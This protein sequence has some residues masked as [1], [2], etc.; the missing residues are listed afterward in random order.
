MRILLN[1]ANLSTGGGLSTGGALIQNWLQRADVLRVLASPELAGFLTDLGIPESSWIQVRQRPG[2]SLAARWA[3]RTL[4]DETV[5]TFQPDIVFTV[6]GPPLWR[7]RAPHVCGFANGLYLPKEPIRTD[8]SAHSRLQTL[9]HQIRRALLFRSLRT[10]TDAIWVETET[11]RQQL[12]R[13]LP[14]KPIFV[15]PNELPDAFKQT[16][17]ELKPAVQQPLR[18]LMPAA[19]Y[20][21]KNFAL[22]RSLLALPDAS[23]MQF[24]VTLHPQ[25]FNR[26]FPDYPKPHNLGFLPADQLPKAY[27]NADVIFA[28]SLAEI[29]SATW[30][31][32]MAAKRPLVC[33]DIPEA[34]DL[35]DNAALYFSGS[36]A[37]EALAVLNSLRSDPVLLAIQVRNGIARLQDLTPVVS[38]PEALYRLLS[39]TLAL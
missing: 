5:R 11:V 29:Y 6:F 18:I 28:P 39:Q 7:P 35:C 21:H 10:D 4:A 19:G 24:S 32:A 36:S 30:L 34:R 38:R 23:N 14:G 26:F 8:N 27:E 20:P 16:A 25:D 33:A 15:V 1:A 17:F 12:Q 37:S 9:S 2:R 3:F 31:E 22:L 13:L